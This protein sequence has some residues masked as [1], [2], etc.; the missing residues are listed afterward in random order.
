MNDKYLRLAESRYDKVPR[1]YQNPESFGSEFKGWVSPYTMGAHGDSGVMIVLQDWGS[2]D[3]F[4]EATEEEL[5]IVKT[6]GRNP[7]LFTNKRLQCLVRDCLTKRL[8]QIYV[9]NAFPYL[10]SGPMSARLP[11]KCVRETITNFTLKEIEIA[12]PSR[13]FLCGRLV[14]NAFPHKEVTLPA[15]IKLLRVPHPAARMSYKNLLAAWLKASG[16]RQ[17]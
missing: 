17:A 2:V 14:W 16:G 5:N 3:R 7:D 15:S 1:G 12:K 6:L 10:K 9:T 11:I 8:E 13:V 4:S